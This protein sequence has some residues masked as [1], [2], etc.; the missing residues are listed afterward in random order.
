MKYDDH[1]FTY[2]AGVTSLGLFHMKYWDAIKEGDGLWLLSSA[3]ITNDFRIHVAVAV[4]A[5]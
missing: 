1:M 5:I 4:S 3:F 2:A